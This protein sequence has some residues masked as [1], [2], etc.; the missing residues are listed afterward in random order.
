MSPTAATEHPR[1]KV[2]QPEVLAP[3]KLSP[4][5]SLREFKLC[6][7]WADYVEL[8][9]L[10]SQPL[11]TQ[12][13]Y[14]RSCLTPEMTATLAHAI[15]DNEDDQAVT[16]DEVLTRFKEHPQRQRNVA[17]LRVRFEERRQREGES[18]DNF[19]HPE[20]TGKRYGAV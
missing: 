6:G 20:G 11:R 19:C 3:H 1:P 16:C 13:S 18:F 17:L 2:H 4:N 8:L 9:Q 12:L 10:K 7:A 5:V 14:L 15:S